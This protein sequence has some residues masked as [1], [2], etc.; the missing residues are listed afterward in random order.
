[1]RVSGIGNPNVRGFQ[2][3]GQMHEK[4]N[5]FINRFNITHYFR[6]LI[7]YQGKCE[8]RNDIIDILSVY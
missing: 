6:E 2:L 8:M 3:K 7:S 1:M 4:L 5:G